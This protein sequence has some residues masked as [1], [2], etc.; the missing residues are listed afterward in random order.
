MSPQDREDMAR[1]RQPGP[2][3][4][5][6]KCQNK[7][8]KLGAQLLDYIR[9]D[10]GTPA[11]FDCDDD[12]GARTF[13]VFDIPPKGETLTTVKVNLERSKAQ[14]KD[15]EEQLATKNLEITALK[16]FYDKI[17]GTELKAVVPP[18][19]GSP[20]VTNTFSDP[21]TA[22]TS[23]TL[24]RPEPNKSTPVNRVATSLDTNHKTAIKSRES[25]APEIPARETAGSSVESSHP[26][27]EHS[28]GNEDSSDADGSEYVS[29]AADSSDSDGDA[30]KK[31]GHKKHP[32]TTTP[33][34]TP[35]RK[36]LKA[37]KPQPKPYIT[38]DDEVIPV[39]KFM[40]TRDVMA[41]NIKARPWIF[42]W[43]KNS[44]NLMVLKCPGGCNMSGHTGWYVDNP[45]YK[46][47]AR[48]HYMGAHKKGTPMKLIM[49]S[50]G[51]RIVPDPDNETEKAMSKEQFRKRVLDL[52]KQT[53]NIRMQDTENWYVQPGREEARWQQAK[54]RADL[55]LQKNGIRLKQKNKER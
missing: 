25:M 7:I 23:M 55:A 33:F 41:I 21:S 48:L 16:D 50:G 27:V 10:D 38:S 53:N 51:R 13:V 30:K 32:A 36:K 49:S 54:R 2:D 8:H 15:L 5:L 31:I 6:T 26:N 40:F 14:V 20:Q 4:P 29:D 52:N 1:I 24:I 9:R 12:T 45:L 17:K 39:G 22:A 35:Q 47:Y 43:P 28:D 18:A 46:D 34:N 44:G 3:D 11:Y 42:E 37:E 19:G